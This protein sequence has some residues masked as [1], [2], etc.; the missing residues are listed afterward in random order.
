MTAK[1]MRGQLEQLR[2]EAM[3]KIIRYVSQYQGEFCTKPMPLYERGGVLQD[4]LMVTRIVV[5]DMD[6]DEPN[7][8]IE[9]Y[10]EPHYGETREDNESIDLCMLQDDVETVV[11]LAYIMEGE[12]DDNPYENPCAFVGS[13]DWAA[14][15][16][17]RAME[18]NKKLTK[19][20]LR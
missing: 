16:G 5:T 20:Y 9:G 13:S 18:L 17:E 3:E 6:T 1:E 10:Y 11:E 8:N 19:C 7:I 2:R 15:Y 12:Y 4:E 14:K